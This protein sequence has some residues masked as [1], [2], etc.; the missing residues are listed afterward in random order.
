MAKNQSKKEGDGGKL[1]PQRIALLIASGVGLIGCLLPWGTLPMVGTVNGTQG[2]GI[3]DMILFAV[4]IVFALVG[5]RP[6]ALDKTRYAVA[7]IGALIAFFAIYILNNFQSKIDGALQ[8][9]KTG[10]ELA[11]GIAS[12]VV[13]NSAHLDYGI[14]LVAIAAITIIVFALASKI[15]TKK[16]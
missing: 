8:A 10:N 6:H 14:Y 5:K 3:I 12:A 9:A 1:H 16:A 15:F 7:A 4:V 11:D 2:D 13:A